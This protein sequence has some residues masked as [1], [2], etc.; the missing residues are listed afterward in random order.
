[1]R[2]S[3]DRFDRDLGRIRLAWRMIGHG[4]RTQTVQRWSGLSR[5]RIQSLY[6][7]Y[8]STA[9]SLMEPRLR[10]RSP[11]QIAFFWQSTQLR[12]EAAILAG[13]FRLF[14]PLP[15]VPADGT[16][17]PLPGLVSGEQL[18]ESYERFRSLASDS[19][20]S[21]EHA[22]LLLLELARGVELRLDRCAECETALVLI[23]VLAAGR[24]V[25]STCAR[26]VSFFRDGVVS[27]S[28][29]PGNE[30]PGGLSVATEPGQQGRLF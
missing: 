15:L 24:T 23:D 20:I 29:N 9:G 22:V 8:G 26:R 21:I 28:V 1:M 7:D 25:C 14:G 11:G 18:C 17:E 27:M 30:D 10:G 19:Q 2:I 4:A 6:R 16:K 3:D 12:C 13:F 5:Y